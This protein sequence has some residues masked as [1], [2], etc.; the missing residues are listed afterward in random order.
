MK[1]ACPDRKLPRQP[2]HDIERDGQHH[3]DARVENDPHPV[4]ARR[5]AAV[6]NAARTRRPPRR[7]NGPT[8]T[9]SDRSDPPPLRDR[10]STAASGFPVE[11]GQPHTFSTA[12]VPSSPVGRI[13]RITI[14]RPK[15]YTSRKWGRRVMGAELLHKRDYESSST[16]PA[17]IAD[18]AHDGRHEAFQIPVAP[19]FRARADS[20]PRISSR[21]RNRRRPPATTPAQT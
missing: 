17:H 3:G 19:N 14:N 9:P 4:R 13:K 12:D 11:A 18:A 2:V 5:L 20:I 6:R 21:A 1:P 15:T 7:P 10:P 8:L 16:A